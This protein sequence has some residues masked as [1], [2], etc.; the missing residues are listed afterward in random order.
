MQIRDR[1]SLR[2][3]TLRR[4][5]NISQQ[6]LAELIDR[7]V[8]AVG[9]FERGVTYPSFET[10]ER[11]AQALGVPVRDFFEEDGDTADP[12]RAALLTQILDIARGLPAADLRVAVQQLE[13]L[14]TRG[15]E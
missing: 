15:G 5:R 6:R 14:R 10:L 8:D 12:E 3:R 7:S 13:A 1:L 9:Q 2:I 4:Q 11:L